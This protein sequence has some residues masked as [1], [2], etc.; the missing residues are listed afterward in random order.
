MKYITKSEQTLLEALALMAPQSSKT[1][2]REWIKEGRVTVDGKKAD[3]GDKVLSEGQTVALGSKI[4][5]V[6]GGIEILFEDRYL[7]AI[8]KPESILTVST[9]FEKKKTA[10]AFLKDH[11]KP[12]QVHVVHRL[13]QDTSGVM[14][15]ARTEEVKDA[16]KEIFEKHDLERKYIAIVEGEVE[17]KKG[18]WSSYLY[19][20]RNYKVHV[21]DDPSKG[22]LAV[23]H[24]KVLASSKQFTALELTLETGKKNQIRVHCQEAGHPVVGDEK[25]GAS[26]NPMKRLGLH[27][28]YLAL[29]HPVTKQ[30]LRFESPLPN[31]FEK[32]IHRMKR[33]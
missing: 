4:H 1:T 32:M 7:V 33:V 30:K 10:Y 13:D 29:Q 5:R 28:R 3:R 19:E 2:L 24:F 31:E 11:F 9:A 27:A 18:V 26:S 25:Y 20:D 17:E 16:L 6:E 14:L 21:T 22:K 15:F 12:A 23:T 8:D